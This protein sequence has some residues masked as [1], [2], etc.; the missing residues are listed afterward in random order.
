M[1]PD[2]LKL[3]HGHLNGAISDADFAKLQVLLRTSAEARQMLR[4]LATVDAKLQ[5]VGSLHT[6]TSK[7]LMI[8]PP[9]PARVRSPFKL[10][11]WTSLAA[12]AASLALVLTG[13][14]FIHVKPTRPQPDVAAVISSAQNAIARLSIEPPSPFPAWA[15]PTASLLDQPRIP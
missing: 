10:P 1:K 12:A 15:S 3:L 4:A 7:N 6:S 2:D 13:T 5:A 9:V 11:A 8:P 14:L